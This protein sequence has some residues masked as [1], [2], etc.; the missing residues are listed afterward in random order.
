MDKGIS[1][2]RMKMIGEEF[3]ITTDESIISLS[4][5]TCDTVIFENGGAINHNINFEK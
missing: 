5:F 2:F 3:S 1:N 4:K